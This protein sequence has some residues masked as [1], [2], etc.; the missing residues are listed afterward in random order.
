MA[1]ISRTLI[2]LAAVAAGLLL[3]VFLAQRRLLYFPHRYGLEPAEREGRRLGLEPW[4]D[5]RGRFI[6]W[7]APRGAGP[8]VA[9]ILVLHGNAGSALDRGYFRDVLQAS[10]VPPVDLL[11]LEYPGYGPRDGSPSERAIVSA[12]TEAIDLLFAEG[13]T[14]VL[15]AG[16]SLGS[17]AASLAAAERP[18]VAGLILVT[19][20]ASVAAVA[21]RHYPWAPSLLLRDRFDTAAALARFRGPVAFLVAGADEVV[22][23][24][25]GLALHAAYPGPKRLWVQEGRG[26]NTVVYERRDPMWREMV[27]GVLT[28]GRAWSS[29]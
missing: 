2:A 28:G 26:H 15:L 27:E 23:A 21:R 8:T 12:A 10:G 16:E 1:T 4:R 29:P 6:G 7:R 13:S 9:R 14:P 19:P 3:L 17:A 20:L 5:A 25:L 11:L 24:D 18:A 22:F